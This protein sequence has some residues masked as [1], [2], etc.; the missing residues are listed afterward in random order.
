MQTPHNT[1]TKIEIAHPHDLIVR[2]F[3]TDTELFKSLLEYYCGNNA[4]NLID[5]NSIKCESPITIDDQLQEVI[6][7]LRFS[8][9]FKNIGHSKV[10]FFFEHQSTKNRKFCIRC[11][12]KLLEFYEE[13]ETNPQDVFND[14]KYPY[15]FVVV[16]YHGEIPWDQLLQ[17]RDLV[18]LPPDVDPNYLSFP[19]VLIDVSRIPQDNLKG[20]P[21]LVALLD[22]L[23]SASE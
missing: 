13:C 16:L 3:L 6:G 1:S 5:F 12:R 17:M 10:F 18:S 15:A 2:H 14:G 8:A 4:I 23:K 22:L 11:L 7:D 20:H 9:Q 19:A 21:A